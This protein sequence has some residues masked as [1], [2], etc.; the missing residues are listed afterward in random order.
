MATKNFKA[1]TTKKLNALLET[2]NEEDKSAIMEVLASRE[3]KA[4]ATEDELTEEEKKVI[5]AAEKNGG[6]NPTYEK[7][8]PAKKMSDQERTELANELRDKY[9][10]N[11]CRV[12]PFN[13]VEWKE[14][15]ITGVIEDKRANKVMYSIK[16]D[17]GRRIVKNHSSNLIEVLDEKIEVEKVKPARK[18][19]AASAK[20]NTPWEP[21]DIEKAFTELMPNVGRN[22]SWNETDKNDESVME[23]KGGR[24]VA[25]VIDKR[26]HRILYR[27]EL[28]QTEE[29]IEAKVAKKYAHKV[30]TLTGLMIDEEFD[31]EGAKLNAAYVERRNNAGVIAK[32]ITNEEKLEKLNAQKEA[33]EA[34]IE[35]LKA[36]L[37]KKNAQIDEL[38]AA[39]TSEA[40]EQ[41]QA[42]ATDELA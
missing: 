3:Q 8:E 34:K 17:D 42:E 27:I 24:I 2:A 9:C 20:V 25:L 15:Y 11:K 16:L 19:R 10:Y 41:A 1:M 29:E 13:T 6:I 14:G 35:A 18:S 23:K 26:G 21:E 39:M 7:S 33:I 5:E 37:E 40:S 38:K 32:P 28:P 22:I 31:E 36:S 12:V 4:P 30:S